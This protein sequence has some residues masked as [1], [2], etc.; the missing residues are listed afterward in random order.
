MTGLMDCWHG[1]TDSMK[2]A[3]F[4]TR[5]IV[6]V[7]NKREVDDDFTIIQDNPSWSR[8][9]TDGHSWLKPQGS[10]AVVEWNILQA[11]ECLDDDITV[12][13][14]VYYKMHFAVAEV[15]RPVSNGD[16]STLGAV[17]ILSH[18]DNSAVRED[19]NSVIPDIEL[20]EWAVPMISTWGHDPRTGV[21]SIV[22]VSM[23][24]LLSNFNILPLS[25]APG[26][27]HPFGPEE[28]LRL[29]H[30]Y[31]SNFAYS[32]LTGYGL[33][34]T[35]IWISVARVFLGIGSFSVLAV[36]CILRFPPDLK[37]RRRF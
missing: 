26:D 36:F 14:F 17:A 11:D 29:Y 13:R 28:D 31:D 20:L 37:S 33:M 15:L 9:Y 34:V 22:R 4:Y 5:E 30:E 19:E 27:S 6:M 2:Y 21:S 3:A 16:C 12:E 7:A 32:Y 10:R 24:R 35:G 8:A 18:D 25:L 23:I 1:L